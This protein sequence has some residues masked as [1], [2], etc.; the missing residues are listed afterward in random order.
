[1]ALT[2]SA[3]DIRRQ[4]EFVRVLDCEHR[5]CEYNQEQCRI[6][7]FTGKKSL[8]RLHNHQHSTALT[9]TLCHCTD[10]LVPQQGRS[11]LRCEALE[12]RNGA[13]L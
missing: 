3:S 12:H 2:C 7:S 8:V 10:P 11:K 5:I 4:V 6:T 1:M 9:N 13:H